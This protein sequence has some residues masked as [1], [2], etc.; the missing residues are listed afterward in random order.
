MN[1]S[2]ILVINQ[3]CDAILKWTKE[4]LSQA[5]LRVVQTFDLH[6]ARTGLHDCSCP[7]HGTD[8]CDCQM[9]VMLVYGKA[10]EPVTLIIHSNDGK[11]WLSLADTPI[12]EADTDIVTSI[13]QA[14]REKLSA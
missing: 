11:T 5:G 12:Q 13:K 3:S 1:I 6:T 9:V 7:H 8:N 10:N 4:Q 14:L 2:P